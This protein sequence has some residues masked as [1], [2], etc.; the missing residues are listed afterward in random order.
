MTRLTV[1]RSP[2]PLCGGERV[3]GYK[4]DPLRWKCRACSAT[5]GASR[6]AVTLYPCS[7]PNKC[8]DYVHIEGAWCRFCASD[9][10]KGSRLA[11][12]LDHLSSWFECKARDRQ[13]SRLVV[14]PEYV[15]PEEKAAAGIEPYASVLR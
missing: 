7:C 5:G 1:M 2:C 14:D 12:R 13:R 4:R 11:R 6:R 15:T 10:T 9:C 8:I 3:A